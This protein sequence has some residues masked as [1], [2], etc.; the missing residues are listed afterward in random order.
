MKIETICAISMA[1]LTI[2]VVA[3]KSTSINDKDHIDHVTL[4]IKSAS[5]VCAVSKIWKFVDLYSIHL[6]RFKNHIKWITAYKILIKWA[7]K[8]PNRSEW[9]FYFEIE[10]NRN[11]ETANEIRDKF[12]VYNTMYQA[13]IYY[14]IYCFTGGEFSFKLNR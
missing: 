9:I 8:H 2:A 5:T 7:I 13:K 4:K 10:K 6:I 14:F 3:E 12:T 1:T 11:N